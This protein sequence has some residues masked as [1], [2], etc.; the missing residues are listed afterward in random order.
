MKRHNALNLAYYV[1]VYQ[2]ITVYYH[3]T[4]FIIVLLLHVLYTH[5]PVR[6][7]GC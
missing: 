2:Y 6:T 3:R 5:L 1:T 7:Y 4:T